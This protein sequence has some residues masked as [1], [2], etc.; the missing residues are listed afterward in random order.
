[1]FS[2]K[3]ETVCVLV[4]SKECFFKIKQLRHKYEVENE[5]LQDS[6]KKKK[7]FI[8][9][10]STFKLCIWTHTLLFFLVRSWPISK[11]SSQS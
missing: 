9:P 5:I 4:F 3:P 8:L 2:I 11:F 7:N 10:H 6:T 1:M